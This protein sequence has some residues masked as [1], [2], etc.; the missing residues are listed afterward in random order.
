[1]EIKKYKKTFWNKIYSR[2]IFTIIGIFEISIVMCTYVVAQSGNKVTSYNEVNNSIE[3]MNIYSSYKSKKF[4]NQKTRIYTVFTSGVSLGGMYSIYHP[5][6]K[7]IRNKEVLEILKEKCKQVEFVGENQ[8]TEEAIKNIIAQKDK[9]DGVLCLGTPPDGLLSIGL[10]VLAVFRLW[11]QWSTFYDKNEYKSK[12]VLISCLPVLPDKDKV[13][14]L[15][16]IEDIVAKINLISAI[17]KMKG[18]RVLV[19]TNK[20]PLGTWEPYEF[21]IETNREEYE[22]VFINNLKETFGASLVPISEKY[23]VEK[24]IVQDEEKAKKVTKK[25]ITESMGI[26]GTNEAQIQRSAKLYL[27]MKELMDE[28]NCD[29]IAIEG[30]GRW[31]QLINGDTFLPCQGLPTSQLLT[32]G[33]VSVGETL[34]NSLITQQLGLYITGNTGQNGD[35]FIDFFNNIAIIAHCD[36]PFTYRNDKKAPYIIR[37]SPMFVEENI[38][39][40]DAQVLY[41]IGETVTVAKIDLYNKK[42]FIFTGETVSGEGL[43]P[44]WNDLLCRTKVA[45]K[46]NAKYD[47]EDWKSIGHHQVTFF[48]DY[49]Q[50]FLDLAKLIG[51]EIIESDKR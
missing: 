10:P 24:T 12:K 30:Y 39:G 3:N 27:A 2:I 9:I 36:G 51:F 25:W 8:P 7:I 18:L 38:G 13:L 11:G 5:D 35:F 29:A 46:T 28:H 4:Q 44:Y 41:P 6:V 34:L 48:G 42:I 23:L 22:K 50:E 45:I 43:F 31:R 20:P 47:N 32:E 40:A 26:R 33:I 19:V 17:S 15:S 49:R 1:M 37:N 16:R 14:Y 21:Q